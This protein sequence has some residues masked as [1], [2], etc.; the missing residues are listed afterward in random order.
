MSTSVPPQPSH[1]T[2][3]KKIDK[4]KLKDLAIQLEIELQDGASRS[5]SI[6]DLSK[7]KP[8]VDAIFRAK[9]MEINTAET[10]PGMDYWYLHTDL[11]GMLEE[12]PSLAKFELLLN[13]W[14]VD[15]FMP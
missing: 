11:R 5:A 12:I 8:L 13:A 4:N 14:R 6:S 10:I 9:A 7:F 3:E 1:I 2:A 15:K